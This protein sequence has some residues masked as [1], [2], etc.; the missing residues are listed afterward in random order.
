M[1]KRG[2]VKDGSILATTRLLHRDVPTL[3]TDFQQ[4][5]R[6]KLISRDL[7]AVLA[8]V[9]RPTQ[10]EIETDEYEG[11][12]PLLQWLGRGSRKCN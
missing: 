6:T 1:C 8:R 7:R 11:C 3:P 10:A 4:F 2:R 9:S 12:V 5:H